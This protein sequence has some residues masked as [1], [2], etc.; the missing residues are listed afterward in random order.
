MGARQGATQSPDS[1]RQQLMTLLPTQQVV[2]YEAWPKTWQ[3]A[4][5][6]AYVGDAH[7]LPVAVP[8][9]V[10]ELAATM[11]MAHANRWQVLVMGQGTKLDWGALAR[12]VD[13]VITTSGL[14]K[15]RDH[16]AADMTVTV[17]AGIPFAQLQ[18]LLSAQQ[19]WLP[20]DPV[21]DQQATLGGI[22]ATRDTGALRHRYG[23]VRDLCLGLTFVRSDG[24]VAKAGGRVVK[25][26]AGY[27][28]MKLFTG[29]FG[30]LG[31]VTELTFRTYPLPED[32]ATVLLRGPA[33]AIATFARQLLQSSLTPVAADLAIDSAQ[34]V[35]TL[36]IRFQTIPDSIA[37]QIQHLK[38]WAQ[39]T[40]LS[41]EE[42]SQ[43]TEAQW[44][45]QGQ[46]LAEATSESEAVFCQVGILPAFAVSVM[47]E[48]QQSALTHSMQLQGRLH[49][50][51]GLGKLRLSGPMSEYKT[52]LTELRSQCERAGGHLSV[53]AA[54][55]SLKQTFDL[56]GYSGN[57]LAAMRTLKKRFDPEGCLNT[58]RFVGGI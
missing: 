34:A 45:Q 8:Y 9:H 21:F 54:P 41:V 23:G 36:G 5:Q 52:V 32:S 17:E 46:A 30:T 56:W 57:A 11:A 7:N 6:S 55:P 4:I 3:T 22:L 1:V 33:D 44:W 47:G 12:Q 16:A 40:A 10:D 15:L 58:G 43:S 27:D 19:Q 18:S 53:L 37:A 25:N 26:V 50:G 31:I 20:V 51:S 39:S 42:L 38:T 28:L 13:L 2:A 14:T 29:S 49:I 35:A 48:M 24:K